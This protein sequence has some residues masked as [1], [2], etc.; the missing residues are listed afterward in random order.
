MWI[1]ASEGLKKFNRLP[2]F[3]KTFSAGAGV[4]KCSLRITATGIFSVKINGT[5]IPD[6]FMP[7]WSNYGKYINICNYD[8]TEQLGRENEI[9]VTVADG[10]YSGRL[11][12][13]G[14][15]NVYGDEK[16]L[17]AQITVAYENGTEQSS[18]TDESWKVGLSEVVSA[19]FFDGEVLDFNG[20]YK[21]VLINAEACDFSAELSDYD[22]EPV[23][24]VETLLPETLYSGKNIIRLDF[25]RNFAGVVYFKAQGESGTEIT[26]R[27][28]EVLNEDGTLYTENLRTAKCTDV[29]VLSSEKAIFDPKF[30]YHGFRYAEIEIKGRA[31]IFD[32]KG[33]VLSQ[34]LRYNGEFECSDALINKIYEIA[35]NGQKSNFIGIPTDCPQRDERLGWTGDA[36]VFCNS[37]MFNADCRKFYEN[38]LKLVR[39]DALPDGRITSFV[40]FYVPVAVNTAGVPAWSDCITVMPYFHFLHYGDK[41]IL[42]DNLPYAEKW[43]GYCL[44]HSENYLI[45][46][47]NNFGDWLSV[48]DSDHDVINQCFFGYSA[49]LTSEMFKITGETEKSE[50]YRELYDNVRAAFRK[51]Y[52]SEGKIKSDTQTVY[53]LSF[54]VGFLSG[55]E[56]RTRLTE[57]I[58]RNGGRITT[59]FIGCRFILPVLCEIGEEDVAYEI[60]RQEEYPSWG[61]MIKLGATTVWERWNGYT[62]EEGFETPEMNSFNHYSLGSCTEWLYTYVLGIKLEEDGTIRVSPSFGKTLDYARGK[63]DNGKGT[64]SVSWKRNGD[65]I[66]IETIAEGNVNY[67]CDFSG[68]EVISTSENGNAIKTVIRLAP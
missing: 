2:V 44:S 15:R 59:G 57:L 13:G 43:L 9:E 19:D 3:K 27:H 61:Y 49:L 31:K 32:I 55:E 63:Y 23:R 40:P 38:Y 30:T 14:K 50:K 21:N 68:A 45:S 62:K 52:Y 29:M 34:D 67:K 25:G 48:E 7:A 16:R 11:G 54:A 17:F 51:N 39:T 18:E 37:A 41:K 46:V 20:E 47:K 12:Y 26:V 1:K 66:E 5:E 28:A 65:R 60:M 53:A 6:Y 4:K 36:E 58:R 42:Y 33:K 64:L 24:A 22:Y 10:W 35:R 8:I 56:I